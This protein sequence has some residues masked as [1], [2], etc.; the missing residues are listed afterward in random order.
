[1]PW[2]IAGGMLVSS[3]VG[4]QQQGQT[5][6]GGQRQSALSGREQAGAAGF[7]P[8]AQAAQNA[9]PT[10]AMGMASGG[11]PQAGAPPPQQG[12]GGGG[13]STLAN[14]NQA[15]QAGATLQ[16]IFQGAGAQGANTR[17]QALAGRQAGPAQP[18][19]PTATSQMDPRLQ[20]IMMGR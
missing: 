13:S 8:T 17:A 10:E 18:F 5:A 3:L 1:M 16:Q 7:T 6:A 4:A 11:P 2:I 15:L 14:T 19:Q 20:Q 12:G 9:A